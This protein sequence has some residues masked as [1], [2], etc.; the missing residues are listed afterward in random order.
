MYERREEAWRPLNRQRVAAFIRLFL[1]CLVY[2]ENGHRR[3]RSH[4]VTAKL[5]KKTLATRIIPWI[6][7]RLVWTMD[8]SMWPMSLE[9]VQEL[10]DHLAAHLPRTHR[11]HHWQT[12]AYFLRKWCG[13]GTSGNDWRT[14]KEMSWRQCDGP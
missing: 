5:L 12:I 10:D 7:R 1:L 14:W 11:G 9:H 4:P 3:G 6:Y 13:K 8:D 2:V